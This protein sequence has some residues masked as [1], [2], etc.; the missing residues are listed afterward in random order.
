MLKLEVI[1]RNKENHKTRTSFKTFA[2]KVNPEQF[3]RKWIELRFTKDVSDGEKPL[4]HSYV[5]V[6]CDK[7]HIDYRNK[8]FP[9]LWIR[10]V[11]KVEQIEHPKED[12]SQYFEDVD[13]S[14][15]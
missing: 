8:Q 9:V 15:E 11:E 13:E 12:L 4:S 10:S 2:V 5:Y 14:N 1:I 7:A 6:E 3:G